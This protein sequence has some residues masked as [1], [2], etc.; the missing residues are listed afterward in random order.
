[1][2]KWFVNGD[3]NKVIFVVNAK[4]GKENK[5]IIVFIVFI[6]KIEP[7]QLLNTLSM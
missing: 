3:F 5:T 7:K 1:M 4:S 6:N 2:H